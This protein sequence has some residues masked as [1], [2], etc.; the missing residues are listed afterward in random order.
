[1]PYILNYNI[2]NNKKYW[3]SNQMCYD[4]VIY[5]YNWQYYDCIDGN[6]NN[7]DFTKDCSIQRANLWSTRVASTFCIW[8]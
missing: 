2:F 3:T 8:M 1:M 6:H 7:T 4:K 5:L